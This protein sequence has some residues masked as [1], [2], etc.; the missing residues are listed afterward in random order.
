MGEFGTTICYHKMKL[1]WDPAYT[2]AKKKTAAER[3]AS[4]TEFA[5]PKKKKSQNTTSPTTTSTQHAPT[6]TSPHPNV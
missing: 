1:M 3:E 2:S 4:R 6:E 5:E